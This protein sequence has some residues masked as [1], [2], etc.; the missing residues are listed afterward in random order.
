MLQHIISSREKSWIN[1][2]NS[3]DHYATLPTDH[4]LEDDLE[5]SSASSSPVVRSPQFN[6]CFHKLNSKNDSFSESTRCAITPINSGE[7]MALASPVGTVSATANRIGQ[8]LGAKAVLSV[9][10]ASQKRTPSSETCV[11]KLN[12]NTVKLS[13]GKANPKDKAAMPFRS[14]NSLERNS[15]DAPA[16]VQSV[17]K[18]ASAVDYLVSGNL[19]TSESLLDVINQE[20]TSFK[21]PP[22]PEP[23][24]MFRDEIE[25]LI[26]NKIQSKSGEEQQPRA[27]NQSNLTK[28]PINV[29]V[30]TNNEKKANTNPKSSK[31]N[32]CTVGLC[33]VRP[34]IKSTKN[35]ANLTATF[36][37]SNQEQSMH[38]FYRKSMHAS[39]DFFQSK[40]NDSRVSINQYMLFAKLKFKL[41]LCGI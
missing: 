31:L 22:A 18:T 12:T 37:R 16:K 33:S 8:L 14:S 13:D 36:L 5:L 15:F 27:S 32:R 40:R 34:E 41:T 7:F 2:E 9:P 4:N 3:Q 11:E 26:F 39:K 20:L 24:D 38:E 23:R 19:D 25:E 17:Q 6:E 29:H 30:K 28:K 10:L 21:V 1:G 35:W